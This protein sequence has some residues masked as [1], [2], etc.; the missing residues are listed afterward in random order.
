MPKK[1]ASRRKSA[2]REMTQL[3]T[4]V[5]QLGS[6]LGSVI[7]RLEGTATFDTVEAL[8]SLAKGRRSGDVAATAQLLK[9]VR[10]LAPGAAFGCAPD[11][12]AAALVGPVPVGAAAAVNTTAPSPDVSPS[13]SAT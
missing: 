13:S 11:L 6:A 7:S 4:E 10:D 9:K 2:L 12:P 3:R 8:R 5:R 1:T